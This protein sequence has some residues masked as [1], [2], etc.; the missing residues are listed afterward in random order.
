MMKY[1]KEKIKKALLLSPLPIL[2][3]HFFFK[4]M[5]HEGKLSLNADFFFAIFLGFLGY[6]LVYLAY[7]I[8][9]VPFSF[10]FSILLNHYSCLNLLNICISSL[11]ISTPF[12]LFL[13]WCFKGEISPTVNS[14]GGDIPPKW[15]MIY[16]DISFLIFTLSTGLF[17]W[18]CLIILKEKQSNI[19][20]TRFM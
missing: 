18:L 7:C 5:H 15:W 4:F 12:C 11:I 3:F 14:M 10:I 13:R 2:L 20:I 6:S 17:Y 9:T 19:V 8:L 16:T 1:S